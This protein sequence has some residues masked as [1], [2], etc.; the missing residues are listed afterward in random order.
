MKK[1]S[2]VLYDENLRET[3][4]NGAFE[5]FSKCRKLNILKDEI[6]LFVKTIRNHKNI[7]TK[8]TSLWKK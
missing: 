8:K 7:N 5:T 6:K 1:M 3:L 4:S 2:N